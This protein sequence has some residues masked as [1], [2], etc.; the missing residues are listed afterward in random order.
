MY[1][2]EIVEQGQIVETRVPHVPHPGISFRSYVW[3]GDSSS[4]MHDSDIDNHPRQIIQTHPLQLQYAQQ[5]RQEST[6]HALFCLHPHPLLL[7]QQD[8][9]ADQE[10]GDAQLQAQHT[11]E[12]QSAREHGNQQQVEDGQ[13]KFEQRSL[14]E[15]AEQDH[16]HHHHLLQ[17]HQQQQQHQHLERSTEQ[18]QQHNI[19]HIPEPDRD[20]TAHL[21]LDILQFATSPTHS[22]PLKPVNDGLSYLRNLQYT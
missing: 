13:H 10:H 3:N 9:D 12:A 11:H 17:Q 2:N 4:A 5:H 7:D 14:H 8:H 22:I 18:Q 16:L 15:S 1:N 19:Y 21:P 6:G 20:T